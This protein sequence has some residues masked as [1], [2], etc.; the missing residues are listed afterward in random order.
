MHVPARCR[1]PREGLLVGRLDRLP[2]FVLGRHFG[3]LS[4]LATRTR[5]D[6]SCAK[7]YSRGNKT[8]PGTESI[9][10]HRNYIVICTRRASWVAAAARFTASPLLLP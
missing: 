9:Y 2:A 1:A 4:M 3:E 5:S 6:K 7:V 8:S 10:G